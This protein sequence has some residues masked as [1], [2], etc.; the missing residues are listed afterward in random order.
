[1]NDGIFVGIDVSQRTLDVVVRPTGE[2]IR[3]DN[4]SEGIAQLRQRLLELRPTLVVLEATG[5]YE[6]EAAIALVLGGMPVAVVN[7]RQVRDF[8]RSMNRFGKTDR[9]DAGVIAMFGEKLNPE[10]RGVPEKEVRELDAL[11]TRRQQLIDMRTAEKNRAGVAPASQKPRIKDHI[12][13][14]D[15]QIDAVNEELESA[16]QESRVWQARNELL[17]SV[18]SVGP[19]TSSTLIARVP[20][21]GRLTGKAIAALIGLAPYAVDSGKYKGQRKIWGGRADVRTALYMSTISAIRCN[22]AI[23]AHY[24]QLIGRGK[25]RKVAIVA[26]MRKLLIILNAMVRTNQAWRSTIA[27]QTS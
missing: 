15:A 5:G 21:L 6:R 20:E 9:V 1:M 12:R 16:I 4:N 22:P 19:V 25:L 11:V 10:A 2:Y 14:L 17:T 26:C 13:Y 8:A 24:E 3:V 18:P 27:V 23:R 7:P